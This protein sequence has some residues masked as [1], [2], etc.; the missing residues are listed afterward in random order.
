M[1]LGKPPKNIVFHWQ[2]PVS[3]SLGMV[4]KPWEAFPATSCDLTAP[5]VGFHMAHQHGR[6]RKFRVKT[7]GQL[8]AQ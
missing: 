5:T 3:L 6:L 2:G 8:L 1:A 7:H 4:V